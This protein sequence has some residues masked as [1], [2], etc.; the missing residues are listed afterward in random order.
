M[1]EHSIESTGDALAKEHGYF[2]RKLKWI[3]RRSAPD[4]LY[5]R[6]DTGPFFVEYKRPGAQPDPVQAREI[7]RMRA[8]GMI[9][10][11]IDNLGEVRE[12]FKPKETA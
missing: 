11:V 2:C 6:E 5:S 7:K 4:K 10:H 9:V 3:G 8:S 1:I 12:L